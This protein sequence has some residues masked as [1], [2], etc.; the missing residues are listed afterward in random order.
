MTHIPTFKDFINL[1]GGLQN[2]ELKGMF[3]WWRRHKLTKKEIFYCLHL[4]EITGYVSDFSIVSMT[5]TDV[6]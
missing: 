6:K 1:E 3:C 5:H 4:L 2:S